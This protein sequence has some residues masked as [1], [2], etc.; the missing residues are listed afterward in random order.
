MWEK[1][2]ENGKMEAGKLGYYRQAVAI[3]KHQR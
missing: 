2:S 3:K 1:V